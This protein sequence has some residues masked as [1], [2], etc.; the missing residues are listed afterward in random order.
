[1]LR[2]LIAG[3]AVTLTVLASFGPITAFFS[4]STSSYPFMV[5]LNVVMF[6][7]AGLLGLS[8][9]LQTLHRLSLIHSQLP[10]ENFLPVEAESTEKADPVSPIQMPA[11]HLLAGHVK[12]VF[13]CWIVVF[14][15]VGAQMSWVLRPFIGN[16]DQDFTWFR[17]R[18]S[19]FF[20]AVWNSILNLFP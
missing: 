16:P 20:E 11:G 17:P 8:F 18:D 15:L 4:V 19:N 13:R 10:E 5:L 12:T 3:I 1:V 2:L 6:A 14:G 7:V 9:L